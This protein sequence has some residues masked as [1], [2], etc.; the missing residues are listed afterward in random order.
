METAGSSATVTPYD[1]DM[2]SSE[3]VSEQAAGKNI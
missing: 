1:I 3:G 2:V